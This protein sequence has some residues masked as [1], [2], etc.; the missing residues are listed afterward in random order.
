MP[1]VYDLFFYPPGG[2]FEGRDWRGTYDTPEQAADASPYPDLA[3]WD[4][5]GEIRWDTSSQ[6]IT[7]AERDYQPYSIDHRTTEGAPGSD[8]QLTLVR[9]GEHT[10][11]VDPAAYAAAKQAGTT[12]EFLA[13]A[14]AATPVRLTVVEPTGGLVELP[15]GGQQ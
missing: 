12:A 1:D 15:T 10:V 2:G 3:D 5:T 9:G 11:M 13:D 4:P 6:R 7:A 14:I 8:I